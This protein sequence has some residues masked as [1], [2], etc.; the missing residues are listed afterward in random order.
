MD[1]QR[2]ANLIIV[3]SGIL[4][5]IYWIPV[6]ALEGLGL[7]GAWGTLAVVAAAVLVLA[8]VALRVPRRAPLG[9]AHAS[10]ALGGLAFVLYSVGLVQGRVAV[11]VL[12][13]FLTPVWSTLIARLVLG[14]R[15]SAHRLAAVGVGIAGLAL[16]L[17]DGGWPVPRAAGEWMALASGVLWAVATTGISE[18]PEIDPRHGALTFASGAL[19]AALIAAPLLSPFPTDP[20]PLLPATLW[21]LGTGALFWGLAMTALTWA[22]RRVEPARVGILLQ[23]EVLVGAASAA[24]FAGETLSFLEIVGGTLV[25]SAGLLETVPLPRRRARS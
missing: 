12:L 22:V 25:V 19:V 10:F 23:S 5:G 4:W 8:P 1:T 24:L 17:G 13:F 16:M 20:V 7:T 15:T 11:I 2:L 18:T 9:L 3:V 14:R 6:R 21:A